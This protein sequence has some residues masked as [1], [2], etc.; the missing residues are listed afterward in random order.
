MASPRQIIDIPLASGLNTKAD[1]KAMESPSLAVAT[2]IQFDDV[3]GIQTRP[4]FQAI[5]DA[6]GNTITQIRKLATYNDELLAFSKNKL[7]SYSAGDG[8]WVDKGDYLAVT[9]DEKPRFVTTGDQYDCDRAEHSGVTFYTWTEDTPS[10]TKS[11]IAAIDES[12]GAVK[13]D[14]EELTAGAIR[15]RLTATK[16]KVILTYAS[17]TIAMRTRSYNPADLTYVADS[18][19]VS[20]LNA[21]DVVIDLADA[22]ELWIVATYGT[23][24]KIF[25]LSE[26]AVFTAIKTRV[27][28]TNYACSITEGDNLLCIVYDGASTNVKADIVTRLGVDVVVDI[29]VEPVPITALVGI[30]QIS[31]VFDGTDFVAIWSSGESSAS[32]LLFELRTNSI[33]PSGS[34]SGRTTVVRRC[35]LVSHAI[36]RSGEIYV[37]GAYASL[38]T[39]DVEGLLQNTYYLFRL[40]GTIMAKSLPAIAG[41]FAPSLGH[42]T[43]PTFDDLSDSIWLGT[44][45]RIII[46][47]ENQRGYSARSITDVRLAFDRDEA[48]RSVSLGDTGY[49]SGGFVAQYDGTFLSEV[50]FNSFPNDV[51]AS[52]GGAGALSGTHNWK[53]SFSWINGAGEIE[54]STTTSVDALTV[55]SRKV[56][57]TASPLHLTAKSGVAAEFWR[58]VDNAAFGAPFF[59]VTSKDPASTGDNSYQENVPGVVTLTA[60]TDNMIDSVLT[61]KEPFPEN[62]GLTLASLPPPSATIITVTQD[63]ILLAG[64]PGNPNRIVYSK[65]RA[66]GEVASF[67]DI[68]FVDLPSVGG[69]I[70]ALA[71]LGENLIVFKENAVYS[72]P[73]DGLNNA[74]LGN[75]Y[76]PGRVLTSDVG[77]VNQ[78]SVAL[79]PRGLIFKSSKGWYILTYGWQTTFIGFGVTEFDDETVLSALVME[80]QHQVRILTSSRTIV[81]DYLV[82]QWAEWSITGTDAIIWNGVYHVVN[83][84]KDSLLA[85]S[86]SHSGAGDLPS[87]DIETGWVKLGDVQGYK[88]IR[89]ILILGEYLGAHDL[90]VRIAYNYVETWIDDKSWTVSPTTVGGPLQLRHK[91]SKP[92]CQSIKI[93]ITAEQVGSVGN[94][95]LT[96]A[97]NLTALSLEVALKEG[98]F[99]GLGAG[100]KQ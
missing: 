16:N 89:K 41:G 74:G 30:N 7:W 49:L 50:G 68:L 62:G 67:H 85:Q 4:Q 92:K 90:R 5:T 20:T 71:F 34:L 39:G 29:I 37:W 78:E 38:S 61:T 56:D 93:R 87:L 100:Q 83:S 60:V 14:A 19:V 26:G 33:D 59:L 32:S 86:D 44:Q 73:G 24:Y 81:W 99:A 51:D 98:S 65:L 48:R 66:Q 46:L 8:L 27:V 53:T 21:Y 96:E 64:I 79:T 23:G 97:L 28:T 69:K 58:Q 94:P 88:L 52:D 91:P 2:D 70:T 57:L 11:Y 6:A 13:L 76:G 10:G 82:N 75:N 80:S 55:T 15:C 77:A 31:C 47:G 3:G 12:S 17:G 54:R 95:P 22:T 40:D 18:A 42:I 35:G 36:I 9:V 72:L 1:S 25:S 84:V 45:R 43:T 63:R